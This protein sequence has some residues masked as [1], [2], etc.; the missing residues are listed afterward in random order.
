MLGAVMVLWV[1]LQRY[2]KKRDACYGGGEKK[3]YE[4]IRKESARNLEERYCPPTC[5]SFSFNARYLR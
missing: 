5:R 4:K 1:A 3:I 2:R